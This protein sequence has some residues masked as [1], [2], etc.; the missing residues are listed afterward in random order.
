MAASGGVPLDV[1]QPELVKLVAL[2]G[3]DP[4]TKLEVDQDG[5]VSLDGP[6]S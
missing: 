3:D 6:T 5:Q 4:E 1:V 2:L